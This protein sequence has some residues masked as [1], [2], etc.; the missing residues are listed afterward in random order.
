VLLDRYAALVPMELDDLGPQERH[1]VYKMLGLR[2]TVKPTGVL[3][4]SGTFGGGQGLSEYV[5]TSASGASRSAR[6]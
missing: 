4:M 3:E 1:R 6:S 5:P 2:V